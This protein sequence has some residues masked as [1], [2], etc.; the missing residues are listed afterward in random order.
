MLVFGGDAPDGC[1]R[2]G[3][4][5]RN[6]SRRRRPRSRRRRGRRGRG[7]HDLHVRHHRE[8]EGR[9]AHRH[10]RESR[11]PRS[12]RRCTCSTARRCTSPP[13]RCTTRVRSRSRCSRTRSAAPSSCCASSTPARGC[14]LVKEHRVTN[15]FTRA[16]P[17]QA[18]RVACPPASSPAPTCRR[19]ARLIANAAPVPY[20]LKQEIIEKL[21]DGFLYE[22]YGSTELGVVTVLPPEDQLRKP[23]SCGKT[24]GGIEVRIVRDDGTD[25]PTGERGRAVHPL[26]ARDGRLPPHRR[27]AHAARRGSGSRSVTSRT[28]TTRA[29]STSATARRT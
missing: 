29:T 9:H 5:R 16:D 12:C 23:G 8:A 25:A 17:A 7:D 1:V 27:E 3:R 15:T 2:L 28:S 18:D 21:G 11:S 19:C 6:A 24:Y 13:G 22:V 4:R 26:D 10:R 14:A 20:S